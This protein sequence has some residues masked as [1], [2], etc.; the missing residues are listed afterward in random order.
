M[1]FTIVDGVV[2]LIL[3]VSAILAFA[4]G[5]TRELLSIGGWVIAAAAAFALAPTFEPMVK[6]IPVVGPYVAPSCE[7]TML[8]AFAGVFAVALIVLSV[9]T[10]AMS[11]AVRDSALGA[12]DRGLGFFFGVARGVILLVIV[13]VLYDI[14]VPD[15]ERMAMIDE[16]TSVAMLADAADTLRAQAPTE[17]P[18]WLA[19]WITG[20]MDGCEVVEAGADA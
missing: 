6:D 4:R 8:T 13:F 18:D 3:F 19:V 9:L 15:G 11:S 2:L 12:I 16:A 17:M 10:T 20:L 1:T 5:F 14:L 7:L